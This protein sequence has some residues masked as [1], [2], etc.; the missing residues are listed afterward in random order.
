MLEVLL[1]Y[2]ILYGVQS[3]V[4]VMNG[5][6]AI[7]FQRE[8]MYR[9]FRYISA[10][11]LILGIIVCSFIAYVLHTYVY[12]KFDLYYIA[13][14]V[15]VLFVGIYNLLVAFIW[16]KISSFKH[17]LYETSYS[18]VMDFAYTLSIIFTLDMS[19]SIANFAMSL[20][21]VA[22]VVLVMNVF[23]GFFVESFNKSYIN[24]NFRHVPSRLFLLAI[25]SIILYYVGILVV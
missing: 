22:L 20:I 21:A 8:K 12:S 14:S 11:F 10:L 13:T 19:V 18:Y 23:V 5:T 15:N 2:I 9:S 6:G 16:T 1:S 7:Q 24:K 3:N 17:Y 4:L 25:F